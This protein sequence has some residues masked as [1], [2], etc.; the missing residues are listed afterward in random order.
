MAAIGAL[1]YCID[2]ALPWH[3]DK[4]LHSIAL[5]YLKLCVVV[6]QDFVVI[7]L[8]FGDSGSLIVVELCLLSQLAL[9]LREARALWA[10]HPLTD[11]ILEMLQSLTKSRDTGLVLLFH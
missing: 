2:C 3:L 11:I 5:S 9:D 10:I 7:Q 4:R 6:V 1:S 8:Q